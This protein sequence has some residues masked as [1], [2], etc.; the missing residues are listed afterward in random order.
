MPVED[1]CELIDTESATRITFD[2]NPETFEDN[3]DTDFA[4]IPILGMSHPHLQFTNGN[5]RTLSFTI[6]LTICLGRGRVSLTEAQKVCV[7]SLS[8]KLS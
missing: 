1:Q 8:R 5:T 4:E 2:I 7:C 3:K 6:I